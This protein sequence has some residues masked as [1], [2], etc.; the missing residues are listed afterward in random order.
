MSTKVTLSQCSDY[1][2]YEECFDKD[3]VYLQ[4]DDPVCLQVDM[5]EGSSGKVTVAVPI[6]TWRHIV[7]GWLKTQWAQNPDW[8]NDDDLD[9]NT[10]E[11]IQEQIE[12]LGKIAVKRKKETKG[13]HTDPSGDSLVRDLKK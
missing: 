5:W 6:E 11:R 8:D 4:L 2:L 9:G 12:W 13:T 3:L 7:E 10:P 1:H